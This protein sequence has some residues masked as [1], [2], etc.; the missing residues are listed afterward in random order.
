M[1][2]ELTVNRPLRNVRVGKGGALRLLSA[3]AAPTL[4]PVDSDRAGESRRV[5]GGVVCT[6][7]GLDA[8]CSSVAAAFFSP[9]SVASF[10]IACSCF[11]KLSAEDPRENPWRDTGGSLR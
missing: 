9:A 4:L 6:D 2:L 10:R 3:V 1:E 7:G 11:A 5:E 8:V